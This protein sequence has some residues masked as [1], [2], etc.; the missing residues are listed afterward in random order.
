MQISQIFLTDSDSQLSTYL[1]SSIEKTKG[2]DPQM[3][4]VLYDMDM[5]RDLIKKKFGNEVLG[6]FD[7]LNPYSY[8]ADLLK[9]CLLFSEGGWYF[10][11]G[12][13]PAIASVKVPDNI[14]AVVFKDAPIISGTTWTCACAVLYSKPSMSVFSRAIEIVV[15]NCKK[16]YYG[17]NALSPTG[18]SVLGRAFAMDGESHNR[19]VGEFISLTPLH[20][21]KNL[22]FVL[23]D[24]LILAYGKPSGGGDLTGIGALG[25]NNYNHFYTSKTV[26]S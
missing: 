12:V 16:S 20:Q 1:T 2:I 17:I 18:P 13:M 9:Y 24:G 15:E 11:V 19:I 14:E 10:D 4:H 23:P 25:T 3:K 26:Y 5:A 8:K 7:K 21:N 22:A 6:A